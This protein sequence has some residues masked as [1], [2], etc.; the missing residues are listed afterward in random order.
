M[1]DLSMTN[2][3]LYKTFNSKHH[4]SKNQS[5]I[6]AKNLYRKPQTDTIS[7]ILIMYEE[8]CLFFLRQ[9]NK[10]EGGAT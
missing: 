7:I 6:Q 8:K 5:K 2:G 9:N 10:K 3:L 1:I 4:L